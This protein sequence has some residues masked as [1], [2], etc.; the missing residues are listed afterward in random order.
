M[1]ALYGE[2]FFDALSLFN[3]IVIH[4]LS[5]TF[6]LGVDFNFIRYVFFFLPNFRKIRTK[7]LMFLEI[8][9]ED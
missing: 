5:I 7:P 8:Y 2:A 1:L 9:I 4:V 6:H 3:I